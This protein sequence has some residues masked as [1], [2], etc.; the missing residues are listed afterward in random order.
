M[1]NEF[2]HPL[3]KISTTGVTQLQRQRP[4]Q[5]AWWSAVFPG[6]GHFLLNQYIRATLLTLSEVTTNSLAHV[7]EAMVLSFCGRFE[8][9]KAV[10]EPRWMFG[11]MLIYLFAIWDSYRSC[12][13]K[14]KLCHLAEI[15][16]ARLPSF[17]LF[18]SEIQYIELKNPK[19]A[20]LSSFLFPGMGQLYN[21]RFF[22][23]FYAIFWWWVY[24]SLSRLHESLMDLIL[25]RLT[26]STAI[27]DPHWL[28]FMPS[29]MMGS[30]YHAYVTTYSH[31]KLFRLEQRQH[32]ALRYQMSEIRL[33]DAMGESK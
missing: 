7:N 3:A 29:V 23:G 20:M 26:E 2:R 22:L 11:Y 30:I 10:L 15:E 1:A 13:Y 12:C 21:H 18:S 27:L 32:L 33:F 24:L 5:V 28:L 6:F 14:T 17:R 9:A 31:N 4:L 19:M 16:N 8:Q 25:G